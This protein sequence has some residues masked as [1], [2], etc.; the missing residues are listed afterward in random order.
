MRFILLIIGA[1]LFGCCNSNK[2]VATTVTS[3]GNYTKQ[4]NK[5]STGNP[6]DISAS[7]IVI[8]YKTKSDFNDKVPVIL[9]D[10]KTNIFE[11]TYGKRIRGKCTT[12]V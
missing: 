9:N 10:D 1:L 6:I 11:Q 4:E 3:H 2:Q 8:I 5:T 7:P 12:F